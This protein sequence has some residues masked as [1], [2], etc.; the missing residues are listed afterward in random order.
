MEGNFASN[1]QL[2]QSYPTVDPFELLKLATELRIKHPSQQ[3]RKRQ[4]SLN[5]NLDKGKHFLQVSKQK[6]LNSLP[7]AIPSRKA[8]AKPS[9]KNSTNKAT[10]FK[11]NNNFTD[12]REINDNAKQAIEELYIKCAFKFFEEK[13][14][15]SNC[16]EKNKIF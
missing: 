8:H 15:S 12:H 16:S 9:V 1:L 4:I 7:E 2:L 6:W 5:L 13:C 11:N 14:Q 3:T 10:W